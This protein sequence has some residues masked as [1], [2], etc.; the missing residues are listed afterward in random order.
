V[1]LRPASALDPRWSRELVG[2]TLRRG[3]AEGEAFEEADLPV[4]ESA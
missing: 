2:L 4:G 1:T 3:L